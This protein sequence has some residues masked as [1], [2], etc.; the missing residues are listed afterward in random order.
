MVAN[1]AHRV[2]KPPGEVVYSPGDL[3]FYWYIPLGV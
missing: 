3:P 1:P 2:V